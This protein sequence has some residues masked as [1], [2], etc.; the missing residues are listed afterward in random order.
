MALA[1]RS[2]DQSWYSRRFPSTILPLDWNSVGAPYETPIIWPAQ[3]PRILSSRAARE[4]RWVS[5]PPLAGYQQGH[6]QR[7][8]GR[9]SSFPHSLLP[10]SRAFSQTSSWSRVG[11]PGWAPRRVTEKAAA[12][13]R[14]RP[15]LVRR[16]SVGKGRSKSAVP[17][18]SGGGRIHRRDRNPRPRQL[19]LSGDEKG[20]ARAQL[21]DD[22]SGSAPEQLPGLACGFVGGAGDSVRVGQRGELR[23]VGRDVVGEGEQRL[24]LPGHR[25]GVQDDPGPGLASEVHRRLDG[26]EGH[27]ELHQENVRADETAPQARQVLGRQAARSRPP[28]RRSRSGRRRPR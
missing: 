4:M 24:G 3:P 13:L 25:S 7:G 16:P 22:L 20:A 12:A 14:E 1:R 11:M 9:S 17:H 19:E 5:A 8:N 28:R 26:G 21:R 2:G 18:V 6:E 23:L 27:L 10:D 15:G